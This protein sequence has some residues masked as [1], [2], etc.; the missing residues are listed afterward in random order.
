MCFP[1]LGPSFRWGL[2]MESGMNAEMRSAQ[3]VLNLFQGLDRNRP[4]NLSKRAQMFDKGA[5]KVPPPNKKG[6]LESRPSD[7]GYDP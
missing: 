3:T 2:R 6:R 7:F 1:E 4:L 5:D